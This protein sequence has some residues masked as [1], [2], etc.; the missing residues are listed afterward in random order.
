MEVKQKKSLGQLKDI[1]VD[2][3]GL[4][5]GLLDFNKL[6]FVIGKNGSGK[7]VINMLTWMST[8]FVN[9]IILKAPHN[10]KEELMQYFID[11][12][13][14]GFEFTGDW[15]VT[16]DSSVLLKTYIENGKV[17]N[18]QI[19]NIE[20]IELP[21]KALYMHTSMRKYD[22]IVA[23]LKVR[24]LLGGDIDK[25]TSYYKLY[26]IY[27]CEML[28]GTL[29][30]GPFDISTI[31]FKQLLKDKIIP[32]SIELQGVDLFLNYEDDKGTLQKKN[33]THFS[34]GEQS[35]INMLTS[36]HL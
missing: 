31:D 10:S 3:P 23:Y 33:L 22:D 2:I 36:P 18:V 29:L 9:Y 27:L 30:S 20:D 15:T 21:T 25:M 5:K 14:N 7:S 16:Y 28:Y 1:S 12:T 24:D 35:L 8:Q 34:A 4:P 13:F 11:N 6:T 19:Y 32:K 26:N 17:T